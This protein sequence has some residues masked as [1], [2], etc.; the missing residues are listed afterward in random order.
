MKFLVVSSVQRRILWEYLEGKDCSP[1]LM[2]QVAEDGL[3]RSGRI[4]GMAQQAGEGPQEGSFRAPDPF[5]LLVQGMAQLQSAV[6]ESLR[7]KT[8]DVEIVKPGIAELPKLAELS[9]NSAIDVGDWLHG[10]QS[11]MGD[12]SNGSGDW[13]K[14]VML[15]LAAYYDAYTRASHV[16]KLAL[17]PE[18]YETPELKDPKWSRVDKRA[19]SMLLASVPE[20]VRDEILHGAFPL[21]LAG[22]EGDPPSDEPLAGGGPGAV[23]TA[24]TNGTLELLAVDPRYAICSNS[25]TRT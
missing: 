8:K 12:L 9:E 14:E 23:V 20:G 25:E 10:L 18:D 16:G 3:R 17:R 22:E 13:W 5:G 6:S 11:H 21:A 24:F 7:S 19:A 4:D 15:S 2:L 1:L